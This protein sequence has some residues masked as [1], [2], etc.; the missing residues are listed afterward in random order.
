MSRRTLIRWLPP[1]LFF[2]VLSAVAMSPLTLHFNSRVPGAFDEFGRGLDYY[3]FHW[4][5]WWLRH[6]LLTGQNIWYTDMVLAPFTHNLAYHSLTA[7][8]LPFYLVLEPLMGHLRAANAIIWISLTLTGL[9]MYAFLRA[10][11][12]SPAIALLGGL[13]FALS[14]YML[15]HAGA[16]HLNLITAW[17]LP[18]IL[19]AWAQ[20]GRTGRARWAIV[21]GLILW[22][23]WFTDTLIVLWGG[24]LL[25]PYAVYALLKAPGA[26]AR[27]R[28]IV[29]GAL[30]LGIALALAWWLGPLQPTLDF[31]ASQLPPARLLTLRYYSLAFDSLYWPKLGSAQQVGMEHDET[32]GLLLVVL[33]AIGLF[34]RV[35]DPER[36]FWLLAALPALI[37]AL[38]PDITVAGVRIPL[39]FR[40]LHAL[41]NGQMRTPIRFLPPATAA[42]VVFLA[43]TYDPLLRRLRARSGRTLIAGVFALLFAVDYGIFAPFPT[44]A[45]LVPYPFHWQMR[46]EHYDDY[47]YVVVDVPSGP[48]TGWR[49]VGS[50]PE[51][52]VYGITHEKRMVSGLLSRTEI[53]KHL[54]FETDPLLGWLTNSHPLDA[55]QAASRL[56]QYVDSWPIGYIVVHQDWLDPARTREVLS[57]F[58]AQSAVCY[59]T[60][61]RGAVLYRTSSHPAGCPPRAWPA[62]GPGEFG[63]ALG[64]PGD[65]GFTG[66]GWQP[67]ENVGGET[68]RWTGADEALLYV[69]VPPD[70]GPYTLTLRA[71]AFD[72]PRTVRAVVGSLVPGVSEAGRLGTVT[73]QPGDWGSYSLTVPAALV[74]DLDGKLAI[75][76]LADGAVSAADLGL[77][78]DARPLAVA[79]DRITLRAAQTES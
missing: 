21:T 26:G 7:S 77:S 13:A 18:L 30:A 48:Y 49:N 19:Y 70:A 9:L 25:G 38:G 12:I 4:N 57:F 6:A 60:T 15:D 23:M 74:R 36:G 73:I 11:R 29:L 37:L 54:F 58:N 20:T 2:V 46:A 76:L 16:G 32:L 17:W 35:R 8:M 10:Q 5:L 34:A 79:Y 52:M 53:A 42:L 61:E 27:V 22:G 69:E 33:T 3:H 66:F 47:D 62:V 39:P 64:E 40:L 75:S 59:V 28:L 56:N 24:L 78:A 50:H 45:A 14:P 68:A 71:V 31:D 44:L 1:A 67:P 43:R 63:L 55:G 72:R 65:E 51:A 41:F